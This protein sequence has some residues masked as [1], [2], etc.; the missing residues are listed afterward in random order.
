MVASK[1]A[2]VSLP[3]A[4]AAGEPPRVH[5]AVR[6]TIALG[7]G[8]WGAFITYFSWIR[9]PNHLAKD[10]SWPWRAARVLLEG[11]NPYHVVQA[12]GP[13][14]FNVG[15]FYPLPAAVVALPFAALRPAVAGALFFGL[16]SALLAFALCRTKSDLAKLPLFL[17]APFCMAAVLVQWSPL[18]TAAAMTSALQ[19]L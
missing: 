14:P 18:M 4:L 2:E 17:S 16:S 9:A 5:P 1:D 8:G 7:L 11:H 13:Y 12:T 6:A 10:F 19:F 15:L 3:D